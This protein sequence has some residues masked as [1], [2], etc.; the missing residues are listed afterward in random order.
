[1]KTKIVIGIM[2]LLVALSMGCLEEVEYREIKSINMIFIGE[3][4]PPDGYKF[5]EVSIK[6]SEISDYTPLN[7]TITTSSGEYN[8]DPV[9]SVS[10]NMNRIGNF[11]NEMENKGKSTMLNIYVIPENDKIKGVNYN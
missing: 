3:Q 7:T 2:L 8:M 6:V 5:I 11:M 9:L 4:F 1:M 10:H